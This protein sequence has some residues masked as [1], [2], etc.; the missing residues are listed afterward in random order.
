MIELEGKERHTG[1][2]QRK[3]W[4][5]TMEGKWDREKEREMEIKIKRRGIGIEIGRWR[6]RWRG[7]GEGRG[8]RRRGRGKEERVILMISRK[9]IDQLTIRRL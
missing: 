5:M 1:N 7:D 3:E 8:E 2:D 6:L 9:S 4:E